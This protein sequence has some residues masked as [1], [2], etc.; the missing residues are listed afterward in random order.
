[1]ARDYYS[2]EAK[3]KRTEEVELRLAVHRISQ[4]QILAEAMKLCGNSV[5]LFNRMGTHCENS[6]RMLRKESD[7]RPTVEVPKVPG[8]DEE[9]GKSI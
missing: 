1:M 7:R 9:G 8:S 4:E 6:L 2:G 5:Q 3:P